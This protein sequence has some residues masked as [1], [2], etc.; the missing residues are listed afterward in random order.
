MLIVKIQR[1]DK[2]ISLPS[3]IKLGDA[4]IDLRASEEKIIK[5]GKKELISTG[6]KVAIPENHVGL[7]WDRSGLA[8]KN[9]LHVLGGVIDSNYRGEIKIIIKNLSNEDFKISKNDRIAQ[10]L[11]Q[12]ITIVNIEEVTELGETNRN[13]KGF[14]SSGIK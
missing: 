11:I 12:P 9:E 4:G 2:E 7:I 14:G 6:V 3:Y 5:Q 10:L 13:D 8:A 1:I